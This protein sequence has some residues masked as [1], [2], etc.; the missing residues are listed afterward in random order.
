M[1]GGHKADGGRVSA[2]PAERGEND[3]YTRIVV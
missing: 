2:E 1:C 3:N